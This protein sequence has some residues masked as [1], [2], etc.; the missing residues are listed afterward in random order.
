MLEDVAAE[1]AK[2]IR[3]DEGS[4]EQQDGWQTDDTAE[5]LEDV[6]PEVIPW[7]RSL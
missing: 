3:M 7:R 4:E 5:G 6:C 2:P 1:E